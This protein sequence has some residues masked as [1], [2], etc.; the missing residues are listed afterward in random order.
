VSE[1]LP[2]IL[3]FVFFV[4]PILERVLKGGKQPPPDGPPEQQLPRRQRPGARGRGEVEDERAGIRTQELP[5]GRAPG[6]TPAE[7]SS[8]PAADMIPDDLW[9]ILTGERRTRPTPP[10][11]VEHEREV[12]EVDDEAE[13]ETYVGE[14]EAFEQARVH[15]EHREDEARRD[16]LQLDRELAVN[17]AE[18]APVHEAPKLRIFDASQ[19]PTTAQRHAAFHRRIDAAVP[20][21]RKRRPPTLGRIAG[22]GSYELRRAV[23]LREVLGPPKALE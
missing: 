4:L 14:V 2:L 1:Y 12:W 5:H 20:A 17:T 23:V 21:P 22:L 16:A 15:L 7:A 9:E 11:P 19:V 3:F 8:D 6:H 18:R 10:A 13:E